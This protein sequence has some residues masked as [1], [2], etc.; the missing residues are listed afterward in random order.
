MGRISA[1]GSGAGKILAGYLNTSD[2]AMQEA[3]VAR[4]RDV[5]PTEGVAPI[6]ARLP[7]LPEASQVKLLAV[8]AGYPKE[9]VLPAILES[10]R[11][12]SVPVRIAA[13]KALEA[14]GGPA[15]VAM[16]V[17]VAAGARGAEQA[18][19]RASLGALKGRAVDTAILD[20]LG[21]QPPED[22]Q[23]ELLSTIADRRIYPAKEAVVS[24]LTAPSARIRLSALKAIR[25]IGTPSDMSAILDVFAKSGDEVE[26][27]EAG[28][29]LT[30]LA[31]KI[32]NPDDRGG[33]I[34]ARVSA[35]KDVQLRARYIG[36]LPLVGDNSALPLLRR[37]LDSTDADVFDA[38]VRALCAWPS[39]AAREDVLELA[40]DSR[41]ET[42]RLLAITGLVRL[43][44][45]DR[46]RDPESAVADLR[47][48]AGFSWRPEE[49]RLVLGALTQ[50]PC[51]GALDLATS[52][53]REPAVAAE[54]EAAIK[55]IEAAV[56]GK[57][58]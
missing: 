11:G 14:V 4:L 19:A 31:Q 32:A 57:G 56:K 10:A 27:T 36:L 8:L 21:K 28:R 45:L 25:A 33:A 38:A 58:R 7:R 35:E 54:S 18:A 9:R 44:R 41:N 6:C 47:Q 49:Q 52:F 22:I 46:Y 43:I 1:G 16:L 42:H 15:E 34:K 17:Q 5:I 48:A 26:R 12:N 24:A 51:R 30:A 55:K 50:F 29:T 3:A 40:R 20:L 2:E 37:A 39:S 13:M 23:A 53:A